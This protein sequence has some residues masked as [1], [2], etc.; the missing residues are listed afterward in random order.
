M[1]ASD[2]IGIDT[3]ASSGMEVGI[4]ERAGSSGNGN[5]GMDGSADPLRTRIFVRAVGEGSMDLLRVGEDDGLSK[6]DV[7]S[8][9]GVANESAVGGGPRRAGLSVGRIFNLKD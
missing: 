5:E 3:S 6:I 7:F 1:G 2:E 8:G 4:R 9:R